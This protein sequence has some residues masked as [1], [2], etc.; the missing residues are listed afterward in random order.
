M[1]L[2]EPTVI[3]GVSVYGVPQASY[4]VGGEAGK[5]YSAALT[6]AAFK[7]ATAIEAAASS[8]VSVVKAR[9]RKVDELGQVMAFLAE[10]FANLSTKNPAPGDTA[11]VNNG[12]WVN[13]TASKYGI[14]LVFQANTAKMTRANICSRTRSPSRAS[15]PSATA[16]SPPPPASSGR[17]TTRAR[18][19]SETSCSRFAAVA[20]PRPQVASPTAEPPDHL[21]T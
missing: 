4:T 11:T 1:P 14:T 5:D 18:R 20:S 10:A 15:S 6:V 13:T 7:Q 8:Y 21:T 12:H 3:P 19:R 17:P 9:A 16:P 2:I